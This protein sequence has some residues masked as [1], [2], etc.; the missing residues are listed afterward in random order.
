MVNVILKLFHDFGNMTKLI[1]SQLH[2]RPTYETLVRDSNLEPKDKIALPDKEASILRRTQQLS[3]YD[4]VE[5]MD[6]KKDNK[7]IA[8]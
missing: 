4:D 8:K 1:K 3:R 6:F 5:F 7:N 2:Q